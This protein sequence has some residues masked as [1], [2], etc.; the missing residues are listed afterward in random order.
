MDVRVCGDANQDLRFAFLEFAEER[1]VEQV[2]HPRR[3]KLLSSA[4]QKGSH[5]S[6][7]PFALLRLR[8][9]TDQA[10]R[11]A[12]FAMSRARTQESV[13]CTAEGSAHLSLS[14][15]QTV[16]APNPLLPSYSKC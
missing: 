4:V 10:L 8:A 15:L 11:S 6:K 9:V 13:R 7:V 3:R 16:R 12:S 1:S 14:G 5:P 2:R